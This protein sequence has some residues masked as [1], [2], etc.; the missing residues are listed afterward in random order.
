MK[1]IYGMSTSECTSS[2]SSK[3]RK[4][5]PFILHPPTQFT[6]LYIVAVPRVEIKHYSVADLIV[7]VRSKCCIAEQLF[8]G[9]G[10]YVLCKLILDTS[11]QHI[12][13]PPLAEDLCYSGNA[14]YQT[15]PTQGLPRYMED[16]SGLHV[17]G[18]LWELHHYSTAGPPGI[19]GRGLTNLCLCVR[20]VENHI[21]TAGKCVGGGGRCAGEGVHGEGGG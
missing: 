2:H 11:T 19:I 5:Q 12:W 14:T 20:V 16:G 8:R 17:E 7:L 18:I 21:F 3:W 6:M 4:E 13:A 15:L 10:S 1:V 9:R